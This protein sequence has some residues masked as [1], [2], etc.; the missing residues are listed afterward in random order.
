MDKFTESLYFDE[1]Q[2]FK[3]LL[4]QRGLFEIYVLDSVTAEP[5]E[6]KKTTAEKLSGDFREKIEPEYLSVPE[7]VPDSK[8]RADLYCELEHDAMLFVNARNM[9]E[10]IRTDTSRSLT[11]EEHERL[12]ELCLALCINFEKA[13][14]PF[15][16]LAE[17][18]IPYLEF[19]LDEVFYKGDFLDYNA[20]QLIDCLDFLVD[21]EEVEETIEKFTV[22]EL[23]YLKNLAL[24]HYCYSGERY[25]R[26]MN[27]R[28]IPLKELLMFLGVGEEEKYT[29]LIRA[30]C[31]ETEE[32]KEDC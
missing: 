17:N 8:T 24:F 31:G 30:Y 16:K 28:V 18:A 25:K 2:M 14:R 19:K 6:R 1:K 15:G 3:Y 4:K 26:F 7:S 29:R 11:Y 20:E 23:D 21:E 32:T 5:A 12:N 9:I 22:R 27:K 13:D 10:K